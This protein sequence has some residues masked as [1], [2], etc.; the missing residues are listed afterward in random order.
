[1]KVMDLFVEYFINMNNLYNMA[2]FPDP[3]AVW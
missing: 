3:E 2:D 1:M